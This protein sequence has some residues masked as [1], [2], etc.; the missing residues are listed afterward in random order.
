MLRGRHPATVDEKGRMKVP[1]A[2]LEKLR[3]G[4]NRFY[5]TSETGDHAWVFPLKAW[6]EIEKRVAKLS[7]HNRARQKFLDRTSYYGQEVELDAQG[8]LLLPQTLRELANLMEGEVAVLGNLTYL[9]VWNDALFR[10]RLTKNQLVEEDERVL[11]A[12]GI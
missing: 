5:I 9:K 10:E 3:R 7:T 4:G 6:E 8:R 11:D 12:L 1:A 2:F